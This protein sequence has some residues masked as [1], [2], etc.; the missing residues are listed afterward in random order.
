[1]SPGYRTAVIV[2]MILVVGLNACAPAPRDLDNNQRLEDRVATDV[3]ATLD[4]QRDGEELP[5]QPPTDKPDPEKPPTSTKEAATATNRIP[6]TI[7]PAAG[8]IREN[9][10]CRSGQGAQFDLLYIAMTGEILVGVAR[11][12]LPDYVVVEIPDKPGME[13]WL[14]TRYVDLLG[15]W[16]NLPQRLPLPTPTPKI[17]FSVVYDFMDGC[18]GW[19]PAFK[20]TNTGNVTYHSSHVK[21]TDTVTSTVQEH[22]ADNFDETNGCPIVQ[23]IPQLDPGKTGWVHAYSFIYD[24]AGNPMQ[25]TVTV[26][27]GPGLTG[28]CVSKGVNF[29]P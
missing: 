8:R 4:A 5:P 17:N 7:A 28:S 11:T 24:P 16:S 13:C 6:P 14:W 21:V 22:T 12:T 23:A 25:A 1:M 20:L 27:T 9:T 18:V 15:D 3:K 19:D 10:N 29:T 2:I 26:C